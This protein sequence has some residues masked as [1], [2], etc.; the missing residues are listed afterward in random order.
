[1]WTYGIQIWGPA[2]P[3]NIRHIQ[4]F[5]SISL[6]LLT[7]APWYIINSALHND[8]KLPTVNELAKS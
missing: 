1:M 5:Q 6:R 3:T 4:A 8:L 7:G 2:K